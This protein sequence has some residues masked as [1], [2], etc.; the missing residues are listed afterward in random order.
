MV[1]LIVGN[2]N[3]GKTER[4]ESLY[5]RT[6]KGDGFITK[7]MFKGGEFQGYE[8]MRLSSRESVPFAYLINFVPIGW[9]GT[10]RQG[11]FSFSDSAFLFAEKIIDEI[12][13]KGIEPV[14]IDEVGP[15]ELEK[16]KGFYS[17]VKKV[18]DTRM[19]IYITVRESLKDK[20]RKVFNIEEF[21]VMRL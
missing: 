17:I 20:F 12:I 10:I 11:W 19:D 1:F 6:R 16:K 7:K 15:L 14:Y 18:L 4:I 5:R 9:D 2:V 3:Q 13:E 21:K 8:I